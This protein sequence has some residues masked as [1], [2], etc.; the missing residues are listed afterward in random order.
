MRSLPPR[1]HK[2]CVVAFAIATAWAVL[3]CVYVYLALGGE[4]AYRIETA[5]FI[6]A[7]LALPLVATRS[8]RDAPAPVRLSPA[9]FALLAAVVGAW[10]LVALPFLTLPFLSDDYGFLSAYRSF[11]DV[12]RPFQFYRPAFAFVFVVLGRAGGGS[13]I[14]FHA[15]AFALHIASASLVFALARRLFGATEPAIVAFSVFLLSPLQFEAVLWA[16]GL[17]EL[18]WTFFVLAAL[19]CYVGEQRL[20]L[21]RLSAVLFLAACGLASKETAVCFVLLLPAADVLFFGFKRGSRQSIAYGAFAAEL[22][23]YLLIRRRAVTVEESF[24]VAP[25]HYFVKQ[26]LAM[27][28]EFFVHPWNRAA[29]DVGFP[30]VC[31]A[32]LIVLGLVYAAVR[33]GAPV[34]SLAG[35]AL[36]LITTLPVY[37]FFY[38]GPDLAGSRY[39]YFA[40][41]GWALLLAE[42]LASEIASR[43]VWSAAIV[44]I[45]VVS[46]ASLELNARPWRT[47][48]EFV[49]AMGDGLRQGRA[50]PD[51]VR[52]WQAH[53]DA[54]FDVRD[55]VVRE[56]Q[57]VG[58]FLNGYPEFLRTVERR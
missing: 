51:I 42:L 14:P 22:L 45:A 15:A 48:G 55:G 3:N 10:L 9:H 57:G 4:K 7:V 46:V 41:A 12:M 23:T 5:V 27:P 28:Y 32:A 49:S 35:P 43:A 31:L 11:S 25:S 52:E 17:Q 37:S 30:V 53:G 58:I 2:A 29:A 6:L 19:R 36:V 24:F 21:G 20:S 54:G 47:A 16:S 26:F 50:A 38:V 8:W 56:Y 13:P 33:Q 1:L 34:R 18:L 44:A 39:L 40:A